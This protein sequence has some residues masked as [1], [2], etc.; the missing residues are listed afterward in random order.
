MISGSEPKESG[1]RVLILKGD[2]VKRQEAVASDTL[3]TID[4]KGQL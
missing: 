1:S 3:E 4:L 2:I